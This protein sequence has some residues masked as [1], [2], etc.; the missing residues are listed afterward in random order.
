MKA[1]IIGAGIGGVSTAIALRNAGVDVV[2]YEQASVLREVGA[3]L[4]LWPNATKAISKLGLASALQNISQQQADGGI[5]DWRGRVISLT[6]T[7]FLER[8][9]G[10]PIIIAHRA[11]LLTLLSES[12]HDIPT[13]LGMRLKHYA[14]DAGSVTATFENGE[15]VTADLLIGADGIKSAVRSQM[16]PTS[17][18]RYSGYT[19]WR[20]VVSF[21]YPPDASY[22]GES[23][24]QGARFGL[25]PLS[26]GRV[27][28]FAVL[29]AP[30]N[31]PEPAEGHKAHLLKHFAGWHH[32]I[33]GLLTAT[34]ESVILHN[35]IYDIQPLTNWVDG[36]VALLG[37]SAHAMTPN[38]G[39]GACQ[40]LED[41]VA[42]GSALQSTTGITAALAQYQSKRLARANNIIVQS[43]RIGQVGQWSNPIACAVRNALFKSLPEGMRN[44]QIAA[45][46]GYES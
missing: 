36:R 6:S 9:F 42:L 16:F 18:P 32:P 11:N 44:N 40:A 31:A 20:A 26:E 33:A 1:I 23:W 46:V 29:N 25:A 2:I 43:R 4:S 35:N 30:E 19:A 39:Q 27:Y 22:W 3:G 12:A 10:A 24:G 8:E 13:H 15:S 21:D 14:Q 17:T 37:D 45:V 38:L 34:D 7:D 41:A 5:H 28:W